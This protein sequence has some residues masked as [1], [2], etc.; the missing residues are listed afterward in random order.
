MQAILLVNMGSPSSEKEMKTFLKNMFLDKAIIAAPYPIRK[1]L[2]FFISN[3]RYKKS[4]SKYELIGG[5][6]LLSAMETI[7]QDLQTSL[8]SEYEVHTAYS[9]SNPTIIEAIK[10][11]RDKGITDILVL[12]MYPHNCVST[13]GS[14]DQ[15]LKKVRSQYPDLTIEVVKEY[16]THPLFID[17]WL[18]LISENIKKQELKNPHL[19]FSAHAIPEYQIIKGDTYTIA[20]EKS[21]ELIAKKLNLKYSVSYQSKIGRIKW[22]SPD[23]KQY[24]CKLKESGIEELLVVPISFLNENLETLYDLDIDIIPYTKNEVHINKACRVN[25]P[26]SHSTLIRTF[27][28]IIEKRYD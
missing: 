3:L 12:S 23:T 26:N 13:T 9:Y 19:L 28:D 4:W 17:F 1:M 20:I 18:E 21:A 15:D 8:S 14:I 5:S 24:I 10:E 11:I 7:K 27:K 22:A 6:P 2:S 25:I 16:A